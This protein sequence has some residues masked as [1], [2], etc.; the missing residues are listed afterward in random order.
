MKLNDL[1]I[2]MEVETRFASKRYGRMLRGGGRGTITALRRATITDIGPNE[3]TVTAIHRYRAQDFPHREIIRPGQITRPWAE[4]ETERAA[5]DAKRE[6]AKAAQ[7]Q[8]DSE[9]A[10]EFNDLFGEALDHLNEAADDLDLAVDWRGSRADY[11]VG[12]VVAMVSFEGPHYQLARF[13]VGAARTEGR[14]YIAL[15]RSTTGDAAV[16]ASIAAGLSVDD[17][18]WDDVRQSQTIECTVDMVRALTRT[19][20]VL[21]H[22][23][24]GD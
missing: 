23:L 7:R 15:A 20:R 8:R 10:T 2:G 9:F 4:V 21:A 24:N 12:P 14:E 22:A 11:G 6:A 19:A 16:Y 18:G 3:V 1:T 5:A 13:I 17:Q